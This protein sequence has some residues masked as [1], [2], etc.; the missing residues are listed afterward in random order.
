MATSSTPKKASSGSAPM[1]SM[2]AKAQK[3]QRDLQD[4]YKNAPVVKGKSPVKNEVKPDI[5]SKGKLPSTSTKPPRN[6]TASKPRAANNISSEFQKKE[7]FDSEEVLAE[8]IV[9]LAGWMKNSLHC[10]VFTGAGI[11]TSTGIADFRSGMNTVLPTGPGVW[12]RKAHG[13]TLRSKQ[14]KAE[15]VL[16]AVPSPSH[17]AIVKLQQEGLVKFVVSQNTDGLHLR[18]G[19]DPNCLAELHGNTYL[20]KCVKCGK[21][22][23]R[24]FRTRTA[25][26][27]HNHLTGR[28]CDNPQCAGPLIDSI[29]NFN[30]DLPEEEL[31]KAF[32]NSKVADLCLVLGSSLRVY[33]AADIPGDMIKRGAKV[34]IVNL[35]KTP[36]NKRCA[37]EV[38]ATIDAVVSGLM[39]SLF[40]SPD[41]TASMVG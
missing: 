14:K 11:S 40:T 26:Q 1:A 9:Q 28:H 4:E 13:V 22:Y 7:Y 2:F 23:M 10:V 18:S 33:P 37:M 15:T 24:D 39:K 34:V 20:E 3:N 6:T 30:E 21:K 5:K 41:S 35:Q 29:I 8:K 27:V 25:R 32:N 16:N 31:D 36:L 38:H 12:E 17:M 19:L